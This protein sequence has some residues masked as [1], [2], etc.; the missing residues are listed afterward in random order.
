[1]P[2]T[3]AFQA[4][5]PW[6][7]QRFSFGTLNEDNESQLVYRGFD[8]MFALGETGQVES[9]LN[10]SGEPVT[11]EDLAADAKSWAKYFA[12]DVRSNHCSN[13]DHDC[14]ET[15]VKYVN[16]KLKAK[17]SLSA[18]KVPS[19]R[20]WFFRIKVVEILGCK[21]RLR[22]RGKPLVA[23]PYIEESDE[24]N[25]QYRCKVK[26][27]HPFRT[28]M[29][30]FVSFLVVLLRM[31][32]YDKRLAFCC[33]S[34]QEVFVIVFVAKIYWHCHNVPMPYGSYL[35]RLMTLT[36]AILLRLLYTAKSPRKMKSVSGCALVR[37]TW[38]GS[39]IT[40]AADRQVCR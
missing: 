5:F 25:D 34:Y 27:E 19:C 32:A 40:V 13:H 11:S 35:D 4:T 3:G 24:R 37:A 14:K 15:C 18:N 6:F 12:E 17:E 39:E 8:N 31:L 29:H 7:R 36:A 1:M 33:V 30:S 9:I 10:V 28:E 21:K 22:R 20:F 2:I 38:R 16:K 23:E 26:R